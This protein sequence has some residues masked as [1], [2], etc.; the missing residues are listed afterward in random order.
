MRMSA[1]SARST[2]LGLLNSFGAE[3][4]AV[5]NPVSENTKT[6]SIVRDQVSSFPSWRT[7]FLHTRAPA[8]SW[9]PPE[10]IRSSPELRKRRR[11]TVPSFPSATPPQGH[12]VALQ[13]ETERVQGSAD[14]ISPMPLMQPI[15]S[16]Q[17]F[18]AFDT[19]RVQYVRDLRS[20]FAKNSR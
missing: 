15:R 3:A 17:P 9:H 13:A 19:H 18:P 20:L 14:Q 4:V 16:S 10:D 5:A 6:T 8:N 11:K 12:R 1:R 7:A 2:V